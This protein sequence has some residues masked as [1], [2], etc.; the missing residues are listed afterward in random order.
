[1]SRFLSIASRVASS[2]VRRGI[3]RVSEEMPISQEQQAAPQARPSIDPKQV[4]QALMNAYAQLVG[5]VGSGKNEN[6][7][8]VVGAPF[9]HLSKEFEYSVFMN[10]DRA[11]GLVDVFSTV[12]HDTDHILQI[13][14]KDLARGSGLT[15]LQNEVMGDIQAAMEQFDEMFPDD[16]SG[17]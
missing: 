7:V 17:G 1:M 2:S 11:K 16:G 15:K 9:D 13:P 6:T 3:V 4:R 5:G 8:G 14:L 10:L 12:H